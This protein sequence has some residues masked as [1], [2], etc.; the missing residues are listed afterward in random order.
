LWH[1][2]RSGKTL[3]LQRISQADVDEIVGEAQRRNT[4]VGYEAWRIEPLT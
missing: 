2:C 4:G 3:S 1:R